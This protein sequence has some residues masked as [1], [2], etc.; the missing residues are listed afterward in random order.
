MIEY[1]RGC[2]DSEWKRLEEGFERWYDGVGMLTGV[3]PP[4]GAREQR[5]VERDGWCQAGMPV[6]W[7]GPTSSRECGNSVSVFAAIRRLHERF[8]HSTA[9]SRAIERR[10]CSL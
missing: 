9:H 7:V 8:E 2:A 3:A 10:R 1:A 6:C 4:G 5:P